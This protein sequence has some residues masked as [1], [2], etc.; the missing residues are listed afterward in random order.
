MKKHTRSVLLSSVQQVDPRLLVRAAGKSLSDTPHISELIL[1]KNAEL[2][3]PPSVRVI[4]RAP[5]S[6]P[7]SL[8]RRMNRFLQ[9]G[10]C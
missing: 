1:L 5:S 10:A 9:V 2:A 4:F 8:L 6:K 3:T 7:P